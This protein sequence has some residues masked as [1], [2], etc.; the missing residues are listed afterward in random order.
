MEC[1]P[2]LR[3]AVGSY[4]GNELSFDLEHPVATRLLAQKEPG[5]CKLGNG[6]LGA[7]ALMKSMYFVVSCSSQT[8][9][10]GAKSHLLLPKLTHQSLGLRT[11]AEGGQDALHSKR[12]LEVTVSAIQWSLIPSPHPYRDKH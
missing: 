4:I 12:E 2:T 11:I 8:N 10:P 7:V 3:L 5:Y 6:G 9:S 1:F